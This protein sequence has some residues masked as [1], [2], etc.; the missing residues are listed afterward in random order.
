[1]SHYQTLGI[2]TKSRIEEIKKAYHQLA[3][4]HHPD[5]GGS[6]AH[7]TEIV[8]AYTT[9]TNPITKSQYDHMH[10]NDNTTTIT[11][12]NPYCEQCGSCLNGYG[13]V[14]CMGCSK[15]YNVV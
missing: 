5:K 4:T 12:S 11:H 8:N 3:L 2:S 15:L 6:D 9:L 14:E 7:F 13:I 1:M 10:N